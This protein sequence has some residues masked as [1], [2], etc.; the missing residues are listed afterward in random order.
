MKLFKLI[1][2]LFLAIQIFATPFARLCDMNK[3]DT[4]TCCVSD[5]IC[6]DAVPQQ[7]DLVKQQVKYS[8]S[9]FLFGYQYHSFLELIVYLEENEKS[10]A[11]EPD[12]ICLYDS[13]SRLRAKLQVFII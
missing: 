5:C 12:H 6:D 8:A 13:Q 10:L 3:A 4:M 7:I 9:D 2:V 11:L 1:L